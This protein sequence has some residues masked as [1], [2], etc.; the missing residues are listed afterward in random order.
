MSFKCLLYLWPDTLI[1]SNSQEKQNS[2]Q[3]FPHNFNYLKN[4]TKASSNDQFLQAT[5]SDSN[6]SQSMQLNYFA[7]CT[8]KSLDYVL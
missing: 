6:F 7:I 2:K 8:K 5:L 1:V 3:S 4:T